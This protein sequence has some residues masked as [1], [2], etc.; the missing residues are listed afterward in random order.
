MALSI[1]LTFEIAWAIPC[2]IAAVAWAIPCTIAAVSWAITCTIA[3]VGGFF[4]S[5]T[6]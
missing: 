6:H 5:K 4:N 1:I 2:T 3:A